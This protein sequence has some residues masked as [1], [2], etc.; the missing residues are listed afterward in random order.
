M[1]ICVY[2]RSIVF[3]W[4]TQHMR[5]YFLFLRTFTVFSRTMF[6]LKPLHCINSFLS[7]F[8]YCHCRR[9][10][11]QV[12][13]IC[14]IVIDAATDVV[15]AAI[16]C[17]FKLDSIAVVAIVDVSAGA[18]ACYDYYYFCYDYLSSI[19][20]NNKVRLSLSLLGFCFFRYLSSDCIRFIFLFFHA[21]TQTLPNPMISDAALS[22]IFML[23][24]GIGPINLYLLC[25]LQKYCSV[26]QKKRTF[27]I[28]VLA[29]LYSRSVLKIRTHPRLHGMVW[30]G[31]YRY[32]KYIL[33]R[34]TRIHTHTRIHA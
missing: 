16:C 1:P 29:H 17:Y 25:P 7:S 14:A 26:Y 18:G 22:L 3:S 5:E 34:H 4:M 28:F 11:L 30:Y 2:A 21:R 33:R 13:K 15:A 31:I 24:F 20:G 27:F 9:R 12:S 6:D 10:R 32:P 23:A 8:Y 19:C